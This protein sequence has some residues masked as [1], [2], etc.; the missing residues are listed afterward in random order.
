MVEKTREI[1]KLQFDKRL[2]LEFHG[3][4]I[5]SDAGLLAC[6]EL[7]NE[8]GDC[9]GAMLRSGNV[10]SAE[11]WRQVLEPI[12]E[13]YRKTGV[14]LSFRADAIDILSVI[15]A[16]RVRM[17]H[18]ELKWEISDKIAWFLNIIF[19][20]VY[21]TYCNIRIRRV[22]DGTT[23]SSSECTRTQERKEKR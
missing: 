21:Y 15:T 12:V 8:F 11:R 22:I 19:T 16:M 7:D 9:E 23:R 20:L 6:R 3:A 17:P 5:T 2:M 18:C 1:L 10:H 14:R 4:R 13:R